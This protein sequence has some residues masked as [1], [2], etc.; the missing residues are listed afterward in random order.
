MIDIVLA[1]LGLVGGIIFIAVCSDLAVTH[2]ATLA[3]LFGVSSLVIGVTIVSV[4]TDIPEIFN[5]IISCSLGHGDIDVGDSL[6]SILNQITL[7][8]GILGIYRGFQVK[9]KEIF[10]IGACLIISLIMIY[11]VI[12][13]GYFTRLNAI[14][15]IASFLFYTIITWNVT[16]SDKLETVDLMLTNDANSKPRR[17]KK[18]HATFAL[19]AFGGVAVSSIILVQ[20]VI[21]LSQALGAPEYVLSFFILSV[22]T[23]L[24]ELAVDLT[25]LRK[26]HYGIA[27]GDVIGS[28][29]V[30]ATISMAIGQALFP[31]AVDAARAIPTLLYAIAA[32]FVVVIVTTARERVDKK[33]GVLFIAV[34]G[35]SFLLLFII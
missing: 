14:F 7:V 33:S 25:A 32:T 8:F 26:K 17:S 4:G 2:A 16:K 31:Q 28:C 9:R 11:S 15:L 20:S 13:K 27:I 10:I 30:D 6:G 5:S 21:T 19:L 29:I 22:G 35:L 1:V 24:P 3:S 12:E 34:Y 23:S 18:Y